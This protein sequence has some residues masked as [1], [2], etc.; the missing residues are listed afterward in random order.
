MLSVIKFVKIKQL[1]LQVL[2]FILEYYGCGLLHAGLCF[3]ASCFFGCSRTPAGYS[4]WIV[5]KP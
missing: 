5:S 3:V 4:V 2:Y 1:I